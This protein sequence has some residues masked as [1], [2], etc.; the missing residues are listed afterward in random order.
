MI[1]LC[2]ELDLA[3]ITR[4]PLAMGVLTGKYTAG[5]RVPAKTVTMI[6]VKG[7]QIH[8]GAEV[9]PSWIAAP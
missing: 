1:T 8:L 9:M 3:A 2:E 7:E 5:T 4:G 6:A